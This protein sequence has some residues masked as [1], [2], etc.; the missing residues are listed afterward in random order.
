MNL[1]PP[2]IL[3]LRTGQRP[4]TFSSQPF[5][6]RDSILSDWDIFGAQD[7]PITPHIYRGPALVDLLPVYAFSRLHIRAGE[8]IWQY[9]T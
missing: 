5:P 4:N 6:G 7:T 8:L 9:G 2:P 1:R 3:Q